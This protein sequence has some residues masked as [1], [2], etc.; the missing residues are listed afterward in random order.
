MPC[1]STSAEKSLGANQTT[2]AIVPL[3]KLMRADGYLDRL[4]AKG[5]LIEAP[6]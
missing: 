5:Y 2:L 3:A 6:K 4:R 1:G